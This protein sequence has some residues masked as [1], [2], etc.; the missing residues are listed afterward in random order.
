MLHEMALARAVMR[1]GSFPRGDI[2]AYTP[3]NEACVHQEWLTG[4]VMYG[5]TSAGGA[6]AVLAV[7]YV[8]IAA[9]CALTVHAAR[10][11]GAPWP[12]ICFLAP[13]A[14]YLGRIALTTVRAQLF[15][16]LFTAALLV[17]IERDRKGAK[18]WIAAWIVA[19]VLWLNMHAGFVVG[20]G[21]L[22]AYWLE[23][24]VR[25]RG[26]QWHLV[27]GGVGLALVVPLNPWGF[28]Y[29]RYLG[30]ALTMARPTISEWKPIWETGQDLH[31]AAYAFM[32]VLA[33]YAGA[34]VKPRGPRG[35]PGILLVTI[36]AYL[37][38][39]GYRHASMFAIVWL[40]YLP[41]WIA[42]TPLG[43]TIADRWRERERIVAIAGAAAAVL[44][45]GSSVGAGL[46]H[47]RVPSRFAPDAPYQLVYPAGAVDYLLAAHFEGNVMTN[48]N[49]GSYFTWKMYP[50]VKV[51]M[52]SRY[53]VAFKPGVAEEIIA[54]YAMK[55][56][57]Q[58]TLAR[59]STTDVLLAPTAGPMVSQI[60]EPWRRVYVDDAF[61][62][63][64]RPGRI[65]LTFTD[66]R[67]QDI[68]GSF[69]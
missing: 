5:A 50:A 16:C 56:G 21:I 48:F 51:S 15:T 62:L 30:H 19:E 32:V 23:N 39:K 60:P 41:S 42:E 7:K 66:R 18:K 40:A 63:F 55:P 29:V 36:T 26:P 53:E 57:W 33:V 13:F 8:V 17:L 22:G 64:A 3:T 37:A 54:M 12:V 68:E 58:A 1:L 2:F 10:L 49:S 24:V 25:G 20:L 46:F 35:M 69:P 44:V 61:T 43:K 9:I 27:A 45:F 31:I 14:V 11:R 4:F 47:V 34:N 6:A 52:D 67:G 28:D 38:A 59:Y 65:D